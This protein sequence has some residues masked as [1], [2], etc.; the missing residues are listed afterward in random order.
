MSERPRLFLVSWICRSWYNTLHMAAVPLPSHDDTIYLDWA[1]RNFWN[2]L[3][4]KPFTWWHRKGAGAA[5]RDSASFVD[6]TTSLR[7]W[8]D[9]GKTPEMSEWQ[10]FKFFQYFFRMTLLDSIA[11]YPN[12]SRVDG[13]W[14]ECVRTECIAVGGVQTAG[15]TQ[16]HGDTGHIAEMLKHE[17]GSARRQK[18]SEANPPS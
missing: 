14:V 16:G 18:G 15:Q 17:A 3:D 12:R 4:S 6:L 7:T 13:T 1:G 5:L 10:H 9:R 2:R 11:N 8:A